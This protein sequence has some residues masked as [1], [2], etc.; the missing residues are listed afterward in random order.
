MDHRVGFDAW[1]WL[2]VLVSVAV[3][4]QCEL[5]HEEFLEDES[6]PSRLDLSHIDRLMDLPKGLLDTKQRIC[7]WG[8]QLRGILPDLQWQ[9]LFDVIGKCQRRFDRA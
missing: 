3:H 8:E 4:G 5:Q 6:Q 2:F 1:S 9:G 7:A